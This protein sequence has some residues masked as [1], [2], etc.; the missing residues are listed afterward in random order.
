MLP[1]RGQGAAGAGRDDIPLL[2]LEWIRAHRFVSV[3]SS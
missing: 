2:G 3:G 1:S